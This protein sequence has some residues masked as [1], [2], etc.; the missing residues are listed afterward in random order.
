MSEK[1]KMNR[2]D[3]LKLGGLLALSAPAVNVIGRIGDTEIV[4]S[5]E[6]FGGFVI[7]RHSKEDPPYQ[8]DDNIYKRYDFRKGLNP[9]FMGAI[10]ATMLAKVQNKE[11]G[12]SRL[13]LAF[14]EGAWPSVNTLRPQPRY[15]R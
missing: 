13:G 7:R 11:Q 2:R 9:L 3:F 12:F 6:E 5:Q 4:E 10:G 8:V 1:S 15:A 14:Q